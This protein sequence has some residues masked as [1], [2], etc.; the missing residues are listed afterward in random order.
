MTGVGSRGCGVQ[1]VQLI[2][3]WGFRQLPGM[4]LNSFV[5]LSQQPIIL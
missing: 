3:A 1:D 4:G 5:G 2:G